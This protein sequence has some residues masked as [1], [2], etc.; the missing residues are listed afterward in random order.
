MWLAVLPAIF[1]SCAA[2][3]PLPGDRVAVSHAD[4]DEKLRGRAFRRWADF[5][6]ALGPHARLEPEVGGEVRLM[7]GLSIAFVVIL[8]VLIWAVVA[9]VVILLHEKGPRTVGWAVFGILCTYA[10]GVE[11]Y[12]QH[13]YADPGM[14]VITNFLFGVVPLAVSSA[15]YV[16]ALLVLD[17]VRSATCDSFDASIFSRLRP[18]EESFDGRFIFFLAVLPGLAVSIHLGNTV[19]T[20]FEAAATH[21]DVLSL[22]LFI[23]VGRFVGHLSYLVAREWSI[24][25]SPTSIS[26]RPGL[27]YVFQ[28]LCL[29]WYFVLARLEA[30]M[31]SVVLSDRTKIH[32]L[33]CLTSFVCF[34]LSIYLAVMNLREFFGTL[35]VPRLWL[36]TLALL[37]SVT[38]IALFMLLVAV[39]FDAIEPNL[40]GIAALLW[41]VFSGAWKFSSGDLLLFIIGLVPLSGLAYGAAVLSSQHAQLIRKALFALLAP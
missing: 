2:T 11:A 31:S 22:C 19:S 21:F 3:P 15:S 33:A 41:V 36:E 38:L 27:C 1:V 39:V 32:T 7:S 30:G 10:A 17:M 13:V 40:M 4:F 20:G 5:K 14:R 37:A 25:K 26:S 6:G 28:A 24:G 8:N 29:G 23:D 35:E 34:P 16:L 18:W 12:C 9:Y